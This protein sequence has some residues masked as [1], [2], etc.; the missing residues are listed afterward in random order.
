MVAERS[1]FDLFAKQIQ[2]NFN[3]DKN[4]HIPFDENGT[5]T[6]HTLWIRNE[7]SYEMSNALSDKKWKNN[8]KNVRHWIGSQYDGFGRQG[9]IHRR[10]IYN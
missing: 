3:S 10:E 4:A 7:I 9:L 5:E 2:Q 6:E 1:R 8:A